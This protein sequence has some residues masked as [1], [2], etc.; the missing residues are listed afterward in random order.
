MQEKAGSGD[1]LNLPFCVLICLFLSELNS[2][3]PAAIY[4]VKH[5]A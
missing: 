4:S 3:N 2:P 1:N 5:T